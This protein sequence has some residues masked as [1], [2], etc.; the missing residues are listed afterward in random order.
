MSQTLCK[1][2]SDCWP[3]KKTGT[4]RGF[5]LLDSLVHL[6]CWRAPR[7]TVSKAAHISVSDCAGWEVESS[8]M[9]A[10]SACSVRYFCHLYLFFLFFFSFEVFYLPLT[11][12]HALAHTHTHAYTHTYTNKQTNKQC[13]RVLNVLRVSAVFLVGLHDLPSSLIAPL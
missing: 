11:H 3:L 8:R 9:F 13:T 1:V 7:D 6:L 10:V 5:D 2:T 12:T 4:A